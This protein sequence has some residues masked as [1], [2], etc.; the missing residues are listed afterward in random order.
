MLDLDNFI[1]EGIFGAT[2]TSIILNALALPLKVCY[3][4]FSQC[5]KRE[6]P[7][8]PVGRGRFVKMFISLEPYGN[9]LDQ[10]LHI[11]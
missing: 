11:Y 6:T 1:S 3:Q 7:G 2:R 8:S 10:I 9:Y 5:Y 4:F